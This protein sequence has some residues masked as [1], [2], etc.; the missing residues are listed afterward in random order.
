M[1]TDIKKLQELNKCGLY[2]TINEHRDYYNSIEDAIKYLVADDE[3]SYI[4]DK[5]II[6]KIIENNCLVRI[7][8]YTK[9]PV[10]SYELYHYDVDEAIKIILDN[11]N[12]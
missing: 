8:A 1:K 7:I 4:E 3:L 12:D 10:G 6:D 2:I 5:E 11:I 9:T